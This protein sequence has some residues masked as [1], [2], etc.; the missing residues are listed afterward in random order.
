VA[1]NVV[2]EVLLAVAH[3]VEVNL[4]VEVLNARDCVTVMLHVG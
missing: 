2:H 3:D 1:C 4:T